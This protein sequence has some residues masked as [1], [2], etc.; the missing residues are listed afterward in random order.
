MKLL[1]STKSNITKNNY[2]KILTHLEINEVTEVHCNILNEDYH[3]NS[4]VS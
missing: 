2:C 3:H 1:E 4:R